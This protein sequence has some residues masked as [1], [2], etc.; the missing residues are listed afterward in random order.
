VGVPAGG[1]YGAAPVYAAPDYVAPA[2]VPPPAPVVALGR[3]ARG[4]YFGARARFRR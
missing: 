1:Y 2:Y 4:A 3:L